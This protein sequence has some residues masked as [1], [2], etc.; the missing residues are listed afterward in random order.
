MKAAVEQRTRL[1][2]F[3]TKEQCDNLIKAFD[4]FELV[5]SSKQM[6]W[7]DDISYRFGLY[8]MA[9]YCTAADKGFLD[10][11]LQRLTMERLDNP[12]KDPA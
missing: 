10:R 11:Q 8:G 3:Y 12:P 4:E 9:A 2:D 5:L 6:D 7:A 1:R